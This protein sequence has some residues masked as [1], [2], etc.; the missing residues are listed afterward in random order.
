[1]T[2]RGAGMKGLFAVAVTCA[3]LWGT[4]AH[5]QPITPRVFKTPP[6]PAKVDVKTGEKKAKASRPFVFEIG[7]EYRT[8]FL[9]IRPLDVSG[10]AA[11]NLTWGEQRLRLDLTLAR[12]GLGALFVQLDALDGVLFGDNG[13]LGRSRRLAL[14][15]VF[16][17]NVPTGPGGVWH[18]GLELT[19]SSRKVMFRR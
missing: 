3:S 13:S 19:H 18:S 5:A 7:A 8:R 6:K 4:A 1:M 2:R 11:E 9:T 15:S 14:G 12:P 17:P 10:L 16:H